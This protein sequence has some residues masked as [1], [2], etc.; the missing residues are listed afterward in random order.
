MTRR[1]LETT[2]RALK[3][4]RAMYQNQLDKGFV[5]ELDA[6][7]LE[8]EDVN[9]QNTSERKADTRLRALQA[10]AT[11]ARLVLELKDRF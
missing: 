2:I 10:I 7:I 9:F 5:K 6:I 8:L 1:S 11:V 3:D 4:A